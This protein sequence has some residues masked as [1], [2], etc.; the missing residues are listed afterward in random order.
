MGE[1]AGYGM[2]REA[3]KQS[4]ANHLYT[5]VH[6]PACQQGWQGSQGAELS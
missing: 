6:K 5:V 1:Q 3:Q 4:R 2:A